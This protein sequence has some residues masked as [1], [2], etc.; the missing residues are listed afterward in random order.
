MKL[1]E[2]KSGMVKWRALLIIGALVS[3]CLSDSVGP[4]LMPLPVSEISTTSVE[5]QQGIDPKASRAP[6]ST[7]GSKPWVEMAS[8]APNRAGARHKQVQP[9]THA[10]QNIFEAPPDIVQDDPAA[11]GPLFL[12]TAS[13]SRPPGRGPPRLV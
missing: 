9:A 1:G 2:I 12:F 6:T 13:V 5:R 7:K 11:Y 8:T 10:P 4:R 3:L